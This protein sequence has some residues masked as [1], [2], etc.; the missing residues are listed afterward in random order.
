MT[1]PVTTL[2][3]S[4]VEALALR[5]SKGQ[6][7]L[8]V[9]PAVTQNVLQLSFDENCDGKKLSALIHQDQSLASHLLRIA[10]S[11]AYAPTDPIV[12]L[13]QAVTR[14]GIGKIREIALLVIANATEL[15]VAG[16]EAWIRTMFT[17]GLAAGMY[18]KR[19]AKERR[20]NAEEGFLCGLLHGIGRP[21]LLH[22][23]SEI[24]IELKV[25]VLQGLP[26]EVVEKTIE[27]LHPRVGG[28][29]LKSWKL[30][31]RLADTI[32]QQHH[33]EQAT[34]VAQ[35]V[36]MTALAA[37]LARHA[38]A[39]PTRHA[40]ITQHPMLW[41]LNCY[42]DELAGHLAAGPDIFQAAEQMARTL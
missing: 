11:P 14:L 3:R 36:S 5:I 27:S 42:E 16:W 13:Q 12:S 1:S 21:V 10:N 39:L 41:P 18:A 7:A 24:E 28:M 8:P 35:T 2:P 31:V 30:P 19:I 26:A 20:W 9:L 22:A 32:S 4:V 34:E 40:D 29:L 6:L 17:L 37:D 15:K 33:F 38:M 25:D 23:L